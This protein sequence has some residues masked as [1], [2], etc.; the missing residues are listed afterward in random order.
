MFQTAPRARSAAVTYK[1]TGV[2][3]PREI[4]IVSHHQCFLAVGRVP[5]DVAQH[6]HGPRR[7]LLRRHLVPAHPQVLRVRLRYELVPADPR[8][9]PSLHLERVPAGPWS[10]IPGAQ[11]LTKNT[12]LRNLT[13]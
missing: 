1:S 8:S 5:P 12:S 4:D 7:R 9:H 13:C 3:S 6:R 2:V 11:N 10:L